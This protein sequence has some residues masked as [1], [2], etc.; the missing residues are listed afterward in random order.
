MLK[1][2]DIVLV[3]F[4]CVGRHAL[5]ISSRMWR[6]VGLVTVYLLQLRKAVQL[7]AL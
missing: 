4:S 7:H 1:S 5:A 2:A 6:K 3:T